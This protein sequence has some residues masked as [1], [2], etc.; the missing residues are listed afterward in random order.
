M[1][2]GP[3]EM[4]SGPIAIEIEI[5]AIGRVRQQNAVTC[6]VDYHRRLRIELTS[7]NQTLF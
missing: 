5:N 3:G 1:T 2:P 4:L 6:D 7:R